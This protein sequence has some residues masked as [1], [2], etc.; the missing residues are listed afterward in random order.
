M[1][2][3]LGDGFAALAAGAKALSEAAAGESPEKW[4]A[5]WPEAMGEEEA[6]A[7]AKAAESPLPSLL[8]EEAAPAGLEPG[9]MAFRGEGE[10]DGLG[11]IGPEVAIRFGIET[12]DRTVFGLVTMEGLSLEESEEGSEEGEEEF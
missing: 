2:A 6:K 1:I 12:E 11:L 10:R 9:E 4:M 8:G 5:I 7:L 3:P